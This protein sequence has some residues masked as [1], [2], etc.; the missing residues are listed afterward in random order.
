MVYLSA[1]GC[2]SVKVA[3]LFSGGKDSTYSLYVAQQRG[4]DVVR[5]LT[6]VPEDQDSMLFHVPNLHLTALQAEALGIARTEARAESG[7]EGEIAALRDMVE[8]AKVE[9]IVTGAI[10]SDYQLSRAQAVCHELGIRAFAPL[11]RKRR[12][13]LLADYLS[14]GFR[15]MFVG[16]S[17]EGMDESWLGRYLDAKAMNDLLMLRG[18]RG[19]DPCGEGGEYETLVLDGPNFERPLEIDDAQRV[20]DGKRGI[21][22]VLGAH[23]GTRKT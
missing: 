2:T 6:V 18:K 21:L 7:E 5:L 23:L 13:V 12:E 3:A 22:R 17:A 20:W 1:C 8:S 4:W 10:A 15:V 14:A 19:V 9:G 16:V 11:W